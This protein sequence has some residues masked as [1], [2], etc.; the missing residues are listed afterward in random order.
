MITTDE[1]KRLRKAGIALELS[2]L[3]DETE[4][5]KTENDILHTKVSDVIA[6]NNELRA[7]VEKTEQSVREYA[8]LADAHRRRAE[9]AESARDEAL[10]EVERLR[11][12]LKPFASQMLLDDYALEPDDLTIACVADSEDPDELTIGD[13]RRARAALA[14]KP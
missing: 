7:R 2:M 12:A 6:E 9:S 10:A 8:A 3:L 5:L 4:R 14:P 1:I 11:E 13:F